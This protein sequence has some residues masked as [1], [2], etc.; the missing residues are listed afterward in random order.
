[1]KMYGYYTKDSIYEWAFTDTIDH[2][3]KAVEELERTQRKQQ[4]S[5]Q[6]KQQASTQCKHN[7]QAFAF[8]KDHID[9][10]PENSDIVQYL[11]VFLAG[12][13]EHNLRRLRLNGVWYIILDDIL[14]ILQLSEEYKQDVLPLEGF[15]LYEATDENGNSVN[16]TM[17][18]FEHTRR[19]LRKLFDYC[20]KILRNTDNRKEMR[21]MRL[22]AMFI[23]ELHIELA[24]GVWRSVQQNASEGA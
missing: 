18:R 13:G 7:T 16:M 15:D 12:A 11:P 3:Q 19:M 14:N 20:V 2:L 23:S 21:T 17:L 5:T 9:A 6:R 1:M 22:T 4:A 8:A 24:V 10:H